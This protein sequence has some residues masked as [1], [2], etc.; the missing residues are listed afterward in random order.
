MQRAPLV[1]SRPRMN[2]RFGTQ[3]TDGCMTVNNGWKAVWKGEGTSSRGQG[4]SSPCRSDD[5]TT[6]VQD[7]GPT[8]LT[9]QQDSPNTL[10]I[11]ITDP[12]DFLVQNLADLHHPIRSQGDAERIANGL[13]IASALAGHSASIPSSLSAVRFLLF[14]FWARHAEPLPFR[15]IWRTPS[16]QLAHTLC[17]PVRHTHAHSGGH[18]GVHSSRHP[19]RHGFRKGRTRSGAHA[20]GL[21]SELSRTPACPRS[22]QVDGLPR[23]RVAGLWR[24]AWH[25]SIGLRSAPCFG[26]C[27]PHRCVAV[28]ANHV[29][30]DVRNGECT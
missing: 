16:A 29:C 7:A 8:T 23:A 20:F 26:A 15:R 5:A 28:S 10:S 25:A 12:S 11:P 13:R 2:K 3:P 19:R 14:T 27:G 6:G 9:P 4:E 18:R 17:A 24:K 22:A 30:S 1:D 21:Q